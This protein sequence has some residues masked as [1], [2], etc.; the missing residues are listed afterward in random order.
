MASSIAPELSCFPVTIGG[1]YDYN[2]PEVLAAREEIKILRKEKRQVRK[3]DN[4]G[5]MLEAIEKRL[6]FLYK[7]LEE[8]KAGYIRTQERYE[9]EAKMKQEAQAKQAKREKRMRRLNTIARL[10]N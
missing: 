4:S 7:L 1:T 5:A 9:Y 8:K 10:L 2:E 6:Q 3:Q